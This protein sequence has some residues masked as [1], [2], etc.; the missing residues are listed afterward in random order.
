MAKA[1]S[2]TY[3]QLTS[4]LRAMRFRKDRTRSTRGHST[5]VHPSSELPIILP[6]LPAATP[7]HAMHLA[8][9]RRILREMGPDEVEQF[10]LLLHGH[11]KRGS[12]GVP[13]S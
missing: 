6:V 5:F 4:A 2:V 11:E 9:V 8:M 12:K 10:D 1:K 7:M 13:V 3:Q